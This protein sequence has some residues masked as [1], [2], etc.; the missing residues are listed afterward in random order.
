MKKITAKWLKDRGACDTKLNLF[1]RI[2][3]E[4]AKVSYKNAKI[5]QEESRYWKQDFE[6]LFSV[7][8]CRNNGNDSPVM[9]KLYAYLYKNN[10]GGWFSHHDLAG[11]LFKLKRHRIIWGIT[12]VAHMVHE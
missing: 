11:A 4:S 6:W 2:F 10:S 1:E 3:G 5:W 8:Y 7:L 12:Q 9:K